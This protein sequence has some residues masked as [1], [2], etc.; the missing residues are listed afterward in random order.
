M[1]F[2]SEFDAAEVG[3]LHCEAVEATVPGQQLNY[4]GL[5][6]VSSP[7]Q[8]KCTF[9]SMSSAYS[10]YFDAAVISGVEFGVLVAVWDVNLKIK[11]CAAI[12]ATCDSRTSN[13]VI[14]NIL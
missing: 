11:Y 3:F 12:T 9:L 13:T 5:D 6:S 14:F 4:V 10:D 7:N 1:A 2:S 8:L